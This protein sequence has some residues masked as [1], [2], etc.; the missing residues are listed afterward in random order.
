[1]GVDSTDSLEAN[2][3]VHDEA[4]DNPEFELAH[5][6]HIEPQEEVEVLVDAPREGVLD[7]DDRVG[8][9]PVHDGLEKGQERGSGHQ[10]HGLVEVGT[11]GGFAEG[12]EFPLEPYDRA[13]RIHVSSIS[14]LRWASTLLPNASRS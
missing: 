5:D 2:A 9:F 10:V 14:A 8:A 12:A 4:V 3:R 7:R 11:G 6:L 1:M 13:F